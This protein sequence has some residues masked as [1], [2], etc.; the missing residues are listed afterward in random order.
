MGEFCTPKDCPVCF[1]FI[2]V[3]NLFIICGK[4]KLNHMMYHCVHGE[5]S[6]IFEEAL[7]IKEYFLICYEIIKYFRYIVK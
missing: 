4:G 6:S 2:C 1:L 3:Q 5:V 7:K